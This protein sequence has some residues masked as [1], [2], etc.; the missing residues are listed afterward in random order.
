MSDKEKAMEEMTKQM[1]QAIAE[2]SPE[3]RRQRAGNLKHM[4]DIELKRREMGK[5][6]KG[7]VLKWLVSH[8][9]DD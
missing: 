8:W 5:N 1:Q 7:G 3:E 9:K 4:L 2:M 6:K